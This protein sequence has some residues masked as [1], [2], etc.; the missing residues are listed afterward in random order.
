[1]ASRFSLL[2][3]LFKSLRKLSLSLSR[4]SSRSVYDFVPVM[5]H[6]L[7]LNCRNSVIIQHATAM[8]IL[9]GGE[10]SGGSL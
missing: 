6:F 8:C 5:A 10:C 4:R 3:L 1:M 9:R 2:A 7:C